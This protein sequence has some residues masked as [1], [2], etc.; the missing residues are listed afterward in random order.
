[1][2]L[3]RFSKT[4]PTWRICSAKENRIKTRIKHELRAVEKKNTQKERLTDII[5]EDEVTVI[6]EDHLIEDYNLR[7]FLTNDGYIKKIP[8]TSLRSSPE[9]KA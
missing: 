5:D 2:R 3:K 1:M 7:I 8:L 9:Q 6:T 4:S